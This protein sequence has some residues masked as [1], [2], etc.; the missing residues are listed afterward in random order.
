MISKMVTP[1]SPDIHGRRLRLSDRA[2]QVNGLKCWSLRSTVLWYAMVISPVVIYVHIWGGM[3]WDDWSVVRSVPFPWHLAEAMHGDESSDHGLSTAGAPPITTS[4][5]WMSEQNTA[6]TSDSTQS[7]E[8]WFQRI[9][10]MGWQLVRKY[11]LQ[12]EQLVCQCLP[13]TPRISDRMLC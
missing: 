5:H 8:F 1:R 7:I 12:T 3:V 10:G 4:R 13:S 11:L 9:S 2:V 6:Q